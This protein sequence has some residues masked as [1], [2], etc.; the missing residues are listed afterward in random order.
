[1]A[2]HRSR[3]DRLA[4]SLALAVLTVVAFEGVSRCG[5]L[6]F[7]D[8]V[9]ITG[10]PHLRDGLSWSG[11]S[12][13][14]S[15]VRYSGSRHVDYV[16]PL[17]LLSR[18]VDVQLFGFDPAAHHLANLL[19]HTAHVV[20]AFLVLE[21]L[22]GGFWRSAF[23]AA[24]LAVHPQ[25]VES[26]AWVTERKDVLSGVFWWLTIGAYV[27]YVRKPGTGRRAAVAILYALALMAKPMVVTLP[28]VLLLLDH[29]PLGRL[30]PGEPGS[31]VRARR[32]LTEK[33]ELFGLAALSAAITHAVFSGGGQLTALETLPLGSRL[34]NAVYSYG[35][36]IAQFFW[37]HP[38]AVHYPY[39][40]H[41]PI[42]H[43]AAAALPMV[44]WAA[45]AIRYW[46][47]RPYLLVGLLMFVGMLVPVIGLVQSGEAA[48]ADRY[49][50]LPSFGLSIA[51]A[52]G[53]A[54]W[55]AGHRQAAALVGVLAL[56]ACALKTRAQVE[57][58]KDTVSLFSYTVAVTRD[59]FVANTN[60]GG[61]LA[62]R[63]DLAGA[64]AQLREA[65]RI[66]PDYRTA[67]VS[68]GTVLTRAG[69]LEDA[70]A[71]CL[72]SVRIYPD[73]A[74]V[75]FGL[76]AVNARLGRDSEAAGNYAAALRLDP[77]LTGAHYNWGNLLTAQGRLSEAAAHYTEAVRLEPQH[78]DARSN[79][80]LA[81][82]LLGRWEEAILVLREAVSRSP[83]HA[84]ARVALGR[85]LYETG[86]FPD[87]EHELRQALTLAPG[88]VDARLYLGQCLTALGRRDEARSVL[89]EALRQSPNDAEV[90]AA[91]ARLDR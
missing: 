56:G 64:E 81:L 67:R 17:T 78:I 2:P 24:L 34:A 37:P 88:N 74:E 35:A 9:L 49:M 7:D 90:R 21:A 41:L 38:L 26:V 59:N 43:V 20:L 10:E 68:L 32:L 28:F 66:R 1:V 47:S 72:E 82:G 45:L 14:F 89:D 52:W 87:A 61:A 29:W 53:V 25:H 48:R 54:D 31:A 65:L 23:V 44:L 69:R 19:F 6:D 39:V 83:G 3:F 55:F 79:L 27:G 63:G 18:L 71:F 80:G 46:R 57:H 58:W 62:A 73:L 42:A 75:H 13:A 30:R 91:I 22:T 40:V 84:R 33:A 16:S 76:G 60:L 11:I 50:Y 85:G 51:L 15:A 77:R 12:W 5:F 70:R 8:N 4:V 86:R 36:Y